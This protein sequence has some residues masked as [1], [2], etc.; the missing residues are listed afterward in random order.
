VSLRSRVLV[1]LGPTATGKTALAVEVARLLDG[2]IISADSRQ[3]Y[4]GLEIG[5]A[6]P[7]AADRAS[8]PHHGVAFLEPGER[9]GAGRFA[10]LCRQWVADIESR[11]RVPI[12]AGGTGFFVSA[13][14]RPVFREPAL[15][16]RRRSSLGAWLAELPLPEVRRWTERLDPDLGSRLPVID[17]QRG[18]RALELA[19]LTGHNLSWWQ[20]HAPPDAEPIPSRTW[21]LEV[22]PE[23]LRRRIRARTRRLLDS[24]W[25]EEVEALASS[26]L[27]L[28]SPALTSIGY[29][30]VWR[31]A[32]G[33]ISRE[34]AVTAIVRDT[35]RYAR[36]QR[37]WLRHQL[38]DDAIR[39]EAGEDVMALASRI[40][41]DWHK[42]VETPVEHQTV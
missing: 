27:R 39:V 1:I 20:Q 40:A 23:T 22:D 33:E 25:L 17:R 9:Y 36:R 29:R 4:R 24:G 32:S 3:A 15:D 37:T 6:A 13:V 2:E 41:A 42:S 11:G 7:S 34:A 28:D 14:T 30:D 38:G 35:W 8:V 12:L 5:T 16:G 19:L 31:L 26:G 21:V 18:G 10:R